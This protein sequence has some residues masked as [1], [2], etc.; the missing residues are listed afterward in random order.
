MKQLIELP[1][2]YGESK[3]LLVALCH[4]CN[5]YH[6]ITCGPQAMLA[7]I[8]EWDCKHSGHETEFI[9]PRRFLPRGLDDRSWEQSGKA[10]WW[11]DYRHNANVK[12]AYVAAANF[13]ITLAS[14]ASDTNLLAGR[15]STVLDNTSNL[16]LDSQLA[17]FISTGTTPTAATIE[18]WG[19]GQVDD[20][21]TYPDALGATDANVTIT[22]VTGGSAGTQSVKQQALSL[23]ASLATGTTTAQKYTF[24]SLSVG[25]LFDCDVPPNKWGVFVVHNTAVAL[26]ATGA[27]HQITHRDLYATVV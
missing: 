23:V 8:S 3:V 22:S 6:E 12:A 18:V 19:F 21:G 2:R 5:H 16:Y 11:A 14:L 10:P 7:Q 9:S 24:G 15:Q 26:N 20:S 1:I 27:N 25:K 4:D 17:G 13:T